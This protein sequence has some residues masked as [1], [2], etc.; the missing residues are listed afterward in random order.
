[1]TAKTL[2]R[3]ICFLFQVNT[4]GPTYETPDYSG[5]GSNAPYNPSSHMKGWKK[6]TGTHDEMRP[7]KHHH[8][9]DK[10]TLTGKPHK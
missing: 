10:D 2:K 4:R 8:H 3:I 6:H 1:M 5:Q 7:H 9:D